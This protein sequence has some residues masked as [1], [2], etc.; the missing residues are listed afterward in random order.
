VQCEADVL[1]ELC[2]EGPKAS[3]VGENVFKIYVKPQ[4]NC[5]RLETVG[6]SR[7]KGKQGPTNS[8]QKA[9]ARYV[10][11]LQA[12]LLTCGKSH[13]FKLSFCGVKFSFCFI[14]AL[15]RHLNSGFLI[16]TWRISSMRQVKFT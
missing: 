5:R 1:L 2:D 16:T 6:V 12:N 9:T 14:L 13:Q 15:E 8:L 11:A 3:S 4:G 10:H 7:R